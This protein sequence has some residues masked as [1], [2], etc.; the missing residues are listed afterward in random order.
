MK[1][2]VYALAVV[3]LMVFSFSANA[4]AQNKTA[5][6][7]GFYAGLTVGA[8]SGGGKAHYENAAW[9]GDY[10]DYEIVTDPGY[11]VGAKFG[12]QTPF[13]KK[14]LALELEYNHIANNF[15]DVQVDTPY[16][17]FESPSDGNFRANLLMFNALARYPD[18]W[19][20]PYVGG[21]VGAAL[22]KLADMTQPYLISGADKTRPAYQ[23]LIGVDFDITRNLILGVGYKFLFIPRIEYD[24]TV[25]NVPTRNT[26]DYNAH[27]LVANI[28]F[29]F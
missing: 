15:K 27:N 26:I 16:G 8:S 14:A 19:F 2:F 28:Y 9:S 24:G 5:N 12:W 22:V 6:N 1:R 17:S 21:G 18:G 10:I 7:L 23:F 3:S 20:H 4:L 11:L 13:T 29:T 25:G